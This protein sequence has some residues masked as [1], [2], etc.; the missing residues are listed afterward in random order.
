MQH[1]PH[2]QFRQ[3]GTDCSRECCMTVC[4]IRLC[5]YPVWLHWQTGKL[6]AVL[7]TVAITNDSFGSCREAQMQETSP[8]NK[9]W[10]DLRFSVHIFSFVSAAKVGKTSLIMSLVSEEFPDE[11]CM[12]AHSAGR[13]GNLL[14]FTQALMSERRRW[15]TRWFPPRSLK[16]HAVLP[17]TFRF[18]CELRRSPYLLMS[19]QRGCPRTLW[20]T[21]VDFYRQ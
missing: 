5:R 9:E 2:C 6:T 7:Q 21:Q 15:R 3:V 1:V 20:T 17:L 4:S 16:S 10:H 12:S 19:P 14:R 11:V 18:P 8:E 13:G